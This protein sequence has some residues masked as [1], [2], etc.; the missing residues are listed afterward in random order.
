MQ[1]WPSKDPNEVLDYQFDWTDRLVT[2]ETITTSTFIVAEGSVTT[3]NPSILAGFTTV[4]IA[5]GVA[6]EVNTITN[7]IVTNQGRTYD[8]S[9]KLRIRSH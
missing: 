1:S 9:A 7:R 2:S 5:G 4:W 6:G 8:E 3:S